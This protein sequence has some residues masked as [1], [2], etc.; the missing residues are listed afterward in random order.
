MEIAQGMET[1]DKKAKGACFPQSPISIG[2][3]VEES[4]RANRENSSGGSEE[5]P[6]THLVPVDCRG[7]GFF[8]RWLVPCEVNGGAC[9]L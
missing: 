1:A 6:S 9:L 7:D 4:D 8:L 2:L 5:S 3:V